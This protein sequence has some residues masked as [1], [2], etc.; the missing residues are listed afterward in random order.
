MLDMK[1]KNLVSVGET[2]QFFI[3]SRISLK[4]FTRAPTPFMASALL[5]SKKGPVFQGFHRLQLRLWI[6]LNMF[7]GSGSGSLWFL[8]TCSVSPTLIL[9]RLNCFSWNF[10][11]FKLFLLIVVQL[12]NA[13]NLLCFIHIYGNSYLHVFFI[14]LSI[15]F[16][17]STISITLVITLSW[18]FI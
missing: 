10:S 12:L 8:L 3:G 7:T 16:T 18:S 5:P 1:L 17:L 9:V 11:D 4:R 6:R 13:L 15:V 2:V 14:A